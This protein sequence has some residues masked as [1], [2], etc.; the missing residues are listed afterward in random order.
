MLIL[1]L[2]KSDIALSTPLQVLTEHLPPMQVV[3][4]GKVVGGM[5]TEIVEALLAHL[6]IK[7]RI[8]PYNWARAYKIAQQEENVL[9]YSITRT[10]GRE[11]KFKWVGHIYTLDTF[12]WRLKS[13]EDI[14][15]NRLPDAKNYVTSVIRQ[16]VQHHRLLD[17]GFVENQH[18]QLAP[19][20]SQALEML[21]RGRV[22]LFIASGAF[23]PGYLEKMPYQLADLQPI[24]KLA[25]NIDRLY[26]A[27]SPK[28]DD[29]IVERFRTALQQLKDNGEIAKIIKRW[30]GR[31]GVVCC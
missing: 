15:V 18:I 25:D 26:I 22:D 16:D 8:T 7:T 13:R 14:Q 9:I 24:V 1:V 30:E 2:C 31:L 11:D 23:M 5:G 20:V 6:D 17:A 19:N 10:P 28:T 4:N 12:I 3:E 21:F 27:F 29:K